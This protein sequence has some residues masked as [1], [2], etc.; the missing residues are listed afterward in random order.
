MK[1]NPLVSLGFYFKM[2]IFKLK[3]L[4]KKIKYS[5]FI[6]A[7][8]SLL[9]LLFRSGPKPSRLAYPCQQAS[10]NNVKFFFLA[11]P[12]VYAQKLRHT[13]HHEINT[14][15]VLNSIA[16]ICILL[17]FSVG[18]NSLLNTYNTNKEVKKYELYKR[19]GPIGKPLA[20]AGTVMF[21]TVPHAF[22]LD[23]PHRV[24]SIHN[25]NATDWD[26]S[27]GHGSCSNYYGDY[28]DQNAVDQMVDQGL[29]EL[30]K[31]A[32]VTQAWQTLLPNYQ[33]GQKIAIKVNFN[34]AI[35][36]GGTDGYG[37]N[38]NYVDALPQ[39]VNSVV[40]GLKA[41][42]FYEADISVFDASRYVTDRFRAKIPYT[43]INYYDHYGNG[44]DVQIAEFNSND[45]AAPIDFT[46][47]GYTG[48]HNVA[49]VLVNSNYLINIPILKRH[50]GTGMTLSLKNHLGSINGFYSGSHNM[51]SYFYLDRSNYSSDVNPLVDINNN[52]NIKDKTVLII[53]DGL[54]GTWPDNNEAPR[55][56]TSFDD[57]SPNMLFFS[58]DPVAIDSVMYDYL[59]REGSFDPKAEDILIIAAQAGM[60][61]H[62]RWN[63]NNDRE[64][65]SINYVEIDTDT[66]LC[67]GCNGTS[68]PPPP[69]TTPPTV[70]STNP[71][72]SAAG[73]GVN[74]AISATFDEAM[75]TN[76]IDDTTFTLSN[77]GSVTGSASYNNGQMTATFTPSSYL[78]Y[79]TT[80]TATV[81]TGVTDSAGNNMASAKAWFFTTGSAPDITPPDVVSTNPDTNALDVAVNVVVTVVFD[82]PMN[83][84]TINGTTFAL[85]NG[86]PIAGSVIYNAGTMTATFIPSADL[87]NSLT[88]TVTVSTGVE[89]SAGNNMASAYTWNFTTVDADVDSDGDG[90]P[91]N[92]DDDP[93]DAAVATPQ[94]TTG[95]GKVIVDTLAN[96]GTALSGVECMSDLDPGLNNTDKPTNVQFPDGLV[97]FQVTG[98]P[99]GGTV[100]V[101]LTFPTAFPAGAEYY[102]ADGTGFYVFP[103]AVING[104]TV[105]MTLTDDG[106]RNGGDS[107]GT[108]GDG[109]IDDPGGVGLPVGGGGASA[110][111]G[112]CFIATAAYG[113]YM[114]EDVMVLRKFRDRHLLSNSLGKGF[115]NLYYRYSPPVANYI[116]EH[117][118]LRTATRITLIPIVYSI[119]YPFVF[120]SVIIM[121]GVIAVLSRRRTRN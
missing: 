117:D 99:A 118:K 13:Y 111:G 103:G 81:T 19:I 18:G 86:G 15:L 29:M 51:H 23:S 85:A 60:G 70:T 48:G 105:T 36:G 44:S 25:S 63:N 80:Y 30:T 4:V 87:S 42:G 115:V 88:Y 108:A 98:V 37:D 52:P 104:N 112:A 82:E 32:S 75:D 55:R 14:K 26:F 72:A 101:T 90:V 61:V 28:V 106:T 45:P 6:I 100:T 78:A 92:I 73:V 68:T 97:S 47:S 2:R 116:A 74:T 33:Q 91:D 7:I 17:L 35:M 120:G 95:T 83:A 56:W 58:V 110:G 53:G 24:V 27:C 57:D 62:E 64:Y 89:D 10:A 38:D 59:M 76:T 93:N 1:D 12:L 9:W 5:S 50:G 65:T 107:N 119:K 20:V 21:S 109:V 54:Y 41:I 49:D 102:K 96:A 121:G 8:V 43:G 3:H 77:G 66:G 94:T 16:I 40:R 22:S 69:D 113:S 84:G 31:T 114:A 79:D 39:I 71:V 34:D 11:A 67:K 46:D